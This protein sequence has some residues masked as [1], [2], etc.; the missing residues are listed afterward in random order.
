MRRKIEL[1]AFT[2]TGLKLGRLLADK[3][4][5]AGRAAG[6]TECF[7][8]GHI[9]LKVWTENAFREAEG[10][11]FIGAAGI[12]VR[13]IAPFV[14]SKAGDPAVVVLDEKAGYCVSL[15]SGHLGGAND[16]ARL[17]AACTGAVPVI[18]TATDVNGLWAAD[19][20]AVHHN[21]R[22]LNP[23]R[24]K[25]VSSRILSGE[26]V[27]MRSQFPVAGKLPGGVELTQEEDCDILLSVGKSAA[28]NP[29]RLVPV[30]AAAGVG[31][32]RGVSADEIER[33]WE[34]LFHSGDLCPEAVK[35]VCSIDLKREEPGL[36]E[37]CMRKGLPFETFPS[38]ELAA[39]PGTY[40]ASS[41]VKEITGVENVCERSAVLGSGGNLLIRKTVCG[42]VTVAAALEL[43]VP[44][45]EVWPPDEIGCMTAR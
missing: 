30:I 16:L 5:E 44:C 32:R 23:E 31:C 45:F 27:F 15:L 14:C 42:G 25:S 11:V 4:E 7:G 33:A 1:I 26:T 41:F 13:A 35:K 3:L 20:W 28:G 18:T 24:I 12:A 37:F 39:V 2:E 34:L 36:V 10:L 8:K 19:T 9:S 17:A 6:L 21:C 43:Y 40:T 29:L 22:V 38:W